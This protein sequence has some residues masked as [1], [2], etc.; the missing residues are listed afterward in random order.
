MFFLTLRSSPYRLFRANKKGRRV[1]FLF[2]LVRETGLEPVRTNHPP[3]KR[4]RL[5]IPPLSHKV[6][7]T[8]LDY[9]TKMF[10]LCQYLFKTFF[11]FFQNYSKTYAF[12]PI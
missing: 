4:A 6:L 10:W 3:L 8:L 9:Y 7:S 11:T 5:P 1:A 2:Y 12:C